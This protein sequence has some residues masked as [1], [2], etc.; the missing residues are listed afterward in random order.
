MDSRPPIVDAEPGWPLLRSL[1]AV[2]TDLVKALMMGFVGAWVLG[3]AAAAATIYCYMIG[4]YF[5]VAAGFIV[6]IVVSVRLSGA[7]VA[8]V[9]GTS[10]A[11]WAILNRAISAP[12]DSPPDDLYYQALPAMLGACIALVAYLSGKFVPLLAKSIVGITLCVALAVTFV[13]IFLDRIYR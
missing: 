6:G 9:F 11:G 3:I 12:A 13:A 8:F 4:I 5:G 1:W 7:D 2:V 10:V